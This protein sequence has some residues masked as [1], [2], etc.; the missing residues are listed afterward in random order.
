MNSSLNTT[1]SSGDQFTEDQIYAYLDEEQGANNSKMTW[2]KFEN[3]LG[4]A[5]E[6][7]KIFNLCLY[8]PI[9]GFLI[10]W[11]TFLKVLHFWK[12]F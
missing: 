10:Q 2:T 12:M 7:E 1:Q 6:F 5:P 4:S 9:S 8:E 3:F 11:Y